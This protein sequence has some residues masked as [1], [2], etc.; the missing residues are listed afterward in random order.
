MAGIAFLFAAISVR[1]QS[2]APDANPPAPLPAVSQADVLAA[3]TKLDPA[4]RAALA[5]D[6]ALLKQVVRLTLVQRLLLREARKNKWDEQPQV[7]DQIERAKDKALAE[8]W[9][10][11]V[12]EP[13]ADYPGEDELKAAWE[14]RKDSLATPRQYRLA[15]IFI[16]CPKSADKNTV[17]KAE[18]KLASVKAKLA[19]Y[20]QDFA[21]IARAESDEPAA[22][23]TGGEIGWLSDAQIQPELRPHITRLIEH[24]VSAP[25][26]LNDGWHLLKCLGKREA[27]TPSFEEARPKLVTQLRAEKMK[28]NSEA[29]VAKLLRSHPLDLDESALIDSVRPSI[30]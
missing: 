21:A 12:A 3:L 11:S 2:A 20:R 13:P 1:A 22:K 5:R 15:Q 10:Q 14:A 29:Y 9:L 16:A 30:K 19:A 4:E 27:G 7:Q 18:A 6:P 23:E 17:K 8:S 26:R 24:E 25:I 28:A